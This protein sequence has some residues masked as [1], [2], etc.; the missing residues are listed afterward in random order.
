MASMYQNARLKIVS[1]RRTKKRCCIV[2]LFAY[3]SV[4]YLPVFSRWIQPAQQ[5]GRRMPPR[6]LSRPTRI[7][8]SRV[9][10]CLA[11]VTQHIHSLRANGVISIHIFLPTSSARRAFSKSFGILCT[12]PSANF[13][14]SMGLL[15]HITRLSYCFGRDYT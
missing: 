5:H 11:D 15:S 4:S 1:A 2:P 12:T 10:S 3:L 7:R 13:I 8:F 9:T 6:I 14:V